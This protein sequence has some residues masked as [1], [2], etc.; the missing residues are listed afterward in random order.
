MST[1]AAT[2]APSTSVE[3]PATP[4][5]A[6][7]ESSPANNTAAAQSA[8]LYVGE[9]EPSVTEAVLFE[10]FNMIGPVASIRVCRD[11]VTRRSLGYGYVNY[12]NPEDCEQAI[13]TFNYT[14][15][16]GKPC[17]IM[18]SQR[19][20]ALRKNGS[21]NIFIKNL[22]AAIDN[23]ALHDTFSA[24]GRILSCKVAT[25]D[26][27][28][29]GYGFVH[30]E[31]D[32]SATNAINAVNGMLLNDKKVYVGYHV[33]RRER[34]SRVDELRAKFTNLY[35]KNI[36]ESVD[37]A[38]FQEL[39]EPYGNITSAVIAVDQ[40]GKSRGFG[41]VNF[42]SHDEAVKAVEG[43]H[44]A[45]VEG[46]KLFVS[47]AQKK[48]ERE[49]ELRRQYEQ[50]K[51]EKLS[52]Y[53]GVNLYVKN[54]EDDVDDDK[55]RQEFS[56]YG[57]ITSAKVMR[58]E[59]NNPKGFGFVCFSTPEEA[60]K[61][62]T[63]MNGRMLG[64]KPIYV[65]I[66]Q[67]KDARRRELEAQAAQ[68]SQLRMQPPMGMPTGAIPAPVYG[69]HPMYYNG[70]QAGYPPRGGMPG[71]QQPGMAPRTNRWSSNAPQGTQPGF[72][73]ANVPGQFN[74]A[75]PHAGYPAGQMGPGG[76]PT[77]GGRPGAP[78]ASRGGAA[79]GRGGYASGAP[80][81]Q[82][83]AP[84]RTGAKY[85]GPRHP[86][87]QTAGQNATPTAAAG[88]ESVEKT[89]GAGS[90]PDAATAEPSLTT[91]TL[92]NAPPEDQKMM[93]GEALY[94]LIEERE[95][96]LA[97]KITGM[98]LEMDNS[99]LLHLLED[100]E[101]RNAKIDEALAVLQQHQA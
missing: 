89:E 88:G 59:N 71:Y 4:V 22:D 80:G 34:Q 69:A 98:L 90:S 68:R 66:A 3:A 20:P 6:L 23:K 91:T 18:W 17:R 15:I 99:E 11:A 64:S 61:A 1:E 73:G 36:D 26:G 42:A 9:L 43:M 19:D 46:K 56:V 45:E 14:E 97:G 38:K 93:L 75:V 47:R 78:S 95:A 39:F 101:A 55:L 2:A 83:N 16:K 51:Y 60:T 29:K 24:F 32:E 25:D 40:E 86:G 94:P 96:E 58:D 87:T 10:L 44:E 67:R 30:F 74:G 35:V 21:G 70:P 33:P 52:K 57:D 48:V 85:Q 84:N 63:E 41:F 81:R 62:V 5:A 28:S 77:R 100:T 27:V 92:A 12:H 72:P 82:G 76:R 79:G 49:D 54:L 53:H 50:A 31:K 7:A 13:D 37:N 65:A 8:S